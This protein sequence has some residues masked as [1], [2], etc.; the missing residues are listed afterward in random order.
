MSLAALHE[1]RIPVY[2]MRKSS[3]MEIIAPPDTVFGAA[4]VR[5]AATAHT[6]QEALE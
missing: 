4:N 3:M 1:H 5:R 6:Q 2:W